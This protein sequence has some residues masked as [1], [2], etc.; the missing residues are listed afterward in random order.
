V[1]HAY[2]SYPDARVSVH[3]EASC[4]HFLKGNN[5]SRRS[6]HM[7]HMSIGTELP[8]FASGGHQFA[9]DAGAY[10]MWLEVDFDD[11][12]FERALVHHVHRLLAARYKPFQGCAVEE[13]C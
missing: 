8:R 13:H 3:R 9:S 6:V 7:T 12:E 1:L 4:A 10:D 2:L 5:F 11:P